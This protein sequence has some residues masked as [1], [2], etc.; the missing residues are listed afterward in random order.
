MYN[1]YPMGP[2]EVNNSQDT[3]QYKMR[4]LF[5]GF[6]FIRVHVYGLLILTKLSCTNN[7]HKLDLTLNKLKEIG[8]KFDL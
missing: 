8:L 3:L 2:T 7:V 1:Y 5:Q 6:E 4:Y